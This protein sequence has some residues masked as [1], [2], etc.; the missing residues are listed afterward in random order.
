MFFIFFSFFLGVCDTTSFVLRFLEEEEEE[1]II[2]GAKKVL[3]QV[4]VY[5]LIDGIMN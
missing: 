3:S 5:T 4:F 1:S 2:K